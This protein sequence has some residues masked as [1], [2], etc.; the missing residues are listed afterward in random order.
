MDKV[1]GTSQLKKIFKNTSKYGRNNLAMIITCWFENKDIK[2]VN[3]LP[4]LVEVAQVLE[5]SPVQTLPIRPKTLV[6]TMS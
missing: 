5:N 4:T 6:D 2:S 1:S 3:L